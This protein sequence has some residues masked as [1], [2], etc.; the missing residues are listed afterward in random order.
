MFTTTNLVNHPY[1]QCHVRKFAD[2]SV[3]FISYSTT[4][5]HITPSGWLYCFGTYSQ[6]TRKQIGWFL[7]EYAPTVSYQTAKQMFTDN[8][9][10]NIHT[11]E[12][13]PIVF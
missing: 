3:Q 13:I 6:T 12:V 5:I 11:G 4:V 1:A 10:C 2:G 8:M 9:V 7:K